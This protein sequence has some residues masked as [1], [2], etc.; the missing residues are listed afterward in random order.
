MDKINIAIV[1]DNPIQVKEISNLCRLYFQNHNYNFQIVEFTNAIMFLNSNYLE[2]TLILLDIDLPVYNG[3]EIAK[4]IR[5]INRDCFICFITD[6]SDY[7]FESYDVHAFDYICKPISKLKLF[8]LLDD[9]YKY[10]HLESIKIH[11]TTFQT[12][13]GKVTL[14]HNEIIYFEYFDKLQ[15]LFNRV[16][17]VYTNDTT[18]IIKEKI[19][20]IYNML[21]DKIFIIPHKSFIINMN[22][23][24]VFRQNEII[25]TN[26]VTIPLSQK[27]ASSARKQFSEFIKENF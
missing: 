4:K 7:I 21:S 8:K 13:I 24:K 1:D 12:T 2:F 22:Y 6:Y 9:V 16:V 5:N 26:N 11:K 3:I 27:R 25:M 17:K 20:N 18:Y 19:S 14:M 15:D 10:T 23:I